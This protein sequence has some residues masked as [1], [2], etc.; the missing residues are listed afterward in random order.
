[1]YLKEK[2]SRNSD[3]MA[4]SV[5]V[6]LLTGVRHGTLGNE[7]GKACFTWRACVFN[8]SRRWSSDVNWQGWEEAGHFCTSLT[9]GG[10]TWGSERSW[11]CVLKSLLPRVL[12]M[13]VFT[14]V[15]FGSWRADSPISVLVFWLF[16]ELDL[17][18]YMCRSR[19]YHSYTHGPS[20][21]A[22]EDS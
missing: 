18:S 19:V 16:W 4:D 15:E 22:A 20:V 14:R 9:R 10:R 1:M 11:S 12:F 7:K 6:Q 21:N 13:L 17:G 5:I 2:S 3:T 8:W